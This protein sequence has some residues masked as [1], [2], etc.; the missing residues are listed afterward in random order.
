MA[1]KLILGICLC[2]KSSWQLS[3]SLTLRCTILPGMPFVCGYRYYYCC[4]Y[5]LK[6]ECIQVFLCQR[7]TTPG[8]KGVKPSNF[9]YCSKVKNC[10]RNMRMNELSKRP[11]E[12]KRNTKLHP[13]AIEVPERGTLYVKS[14]DC[15]Q[16]YWFVYLKQMPSEV[17]QSVL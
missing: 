11:H 5:S 2:F 3:G 6:W 17:V 1:G 8:D 9:L 4:Y 7:L 12:P 13:A 14:L 10:R 16:F 15:R